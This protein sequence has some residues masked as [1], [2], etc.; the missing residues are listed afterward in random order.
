MRIHVPALARLSFLDI[1]LEIDVG[2][3]AS[4]AKLAQFVQVAPL[5]LARLWSMTETSC[6]MGSSA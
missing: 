6:S 3:A 5:A 4:A 2:L 1:G